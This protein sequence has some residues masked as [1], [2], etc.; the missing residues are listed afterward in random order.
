MSDVLRRTQAAFPRSSFV[1]PEAPCTIV[2]IEDEEPLRRLM[3][4]MLVPE[5]CIV[6]E[7]T[8]GERGLRLIEQHPV[9]LDLVLTDIQ[10]PE[11][12]G[13]QVAKVLASFRP[14]LP[15]ICMSGK[16]DEAVVEKRLGQARRPFLVKPF[17]ADELL[18]TVVEALTHSQELLVRAQPHLT[19]ALGLVV[20]HDQLDAATVDLVAAARRLRCRRIR[21]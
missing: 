12:D 8:D 6:L 20:E 14:L 4:R 3:R 11:I 1:A 21:H 15:V 9:G 5:G 18:Q 17:T 13:I 10:M 2:V 19:L 7:A 16:V